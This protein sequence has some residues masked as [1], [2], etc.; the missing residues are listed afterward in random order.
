MDLYLCY[1]AEGPR[2][3]NRLQWL[4]DAEEPQLG[5]AAKME[6]WGQRYDGRSSAFGDWARRKQEEGK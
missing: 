3:V 2:Y 5:K 4:P 1:C 6:D